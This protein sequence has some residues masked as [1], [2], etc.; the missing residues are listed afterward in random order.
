MCDRPT[1]VAVRAVRHIQ[2]LLLTLLVELIEITQNPGENNDIQDGER[3]QG[4][5]MSILKSTDDCLGV[6]NTLLR[7]PLVIAGGAQKNGDMRPSR[8]C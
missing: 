7:V 4:E 2:S 5:L 3:C 1:A 6:D 8:H